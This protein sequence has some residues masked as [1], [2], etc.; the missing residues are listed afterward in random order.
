VE[1]EPMTR[2][3][4]KGRSPSQVALHKSRISRMG[5]WLHW[6]IVRAKSAATFC[7]GSS[8]LLFRP[9]RFSEG[10][11]TTDGTWSAS[12]FQH[13]RMPADRPVSDFPFHE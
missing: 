5:K 4:P 2:D 10:S 11:F 8:V 1:G 9:A 6:Q 12:A 7:L 3:N 13:Y